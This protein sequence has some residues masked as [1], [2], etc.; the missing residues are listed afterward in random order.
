MRVSINPTST[1]KY[2]N[3]GLRLFILVKLSKSCKS[4]F[5]DINILDIFYDCVQSFI[6]LSI[7]PFVFK[8]K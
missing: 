7:H 4:C 3:G 5:L 2:K 1:K 8:L 6:K